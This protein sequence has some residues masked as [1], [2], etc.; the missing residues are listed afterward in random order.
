MVYKGYRQ[1]FFCVHKSKIEKGDPN[2]QKG[3]HRDPGPI[4]APDSLFSIERIHWGTVGEAH[5]VGGGG[6]HQPPVHQSL[7]PP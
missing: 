4:G 2:P 1:L 6:D 5:W 7:C 3:P